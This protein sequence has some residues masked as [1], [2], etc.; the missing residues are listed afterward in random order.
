MVIEKPICI[1]KQE[2]QDELSAV[3]KAKVKTQTGFVLR[4]DPQVYFIKKIEYCPAM[5]GRFEVSEKAFIL[6]AP[7]NLFWY[8]FKIFFSA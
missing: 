3:R 7:F 5:C 4:Y 2:L 8:V 6:L 1:N